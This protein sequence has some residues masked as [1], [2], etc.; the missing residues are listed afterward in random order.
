MK[1]ELAAAL[2]HRP[3][4]LFL[5]EPTIGLDVTSQR[6]IRTFIAEY[7]R[8]HEA[9]A[10][11]TSH[12]MA[13]VEALCRRVILIHHGQI[14]FDGNLRELA[15][16]FSSYKT[17]TVQT[18]DGAVGAGVERRRD[19]ELAS[20]LRDVSLPPSWSS[21]GEVISAEEGQVKL[22]VPKAATARVV[23]RLLEERAISDLTIEDPPLD[24]VIEQV[25]AQEVVA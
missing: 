20:A 11:L 6:R 19:G 12:Y 10:L 25:F 7:N 9:T 18:A 17:I 22:R 4:V 21:F 1:C 8:R 5:D 24:Q 14:L 15:Q 16:R 23:Q 3:R 2:L 13:D